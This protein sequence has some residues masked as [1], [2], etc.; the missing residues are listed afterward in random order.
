MS[1]GFKTVNQDALHFITPTIINWVDLF[2]R[3]VYRDIVI[4][5]LRYCQ[6][7]KGLEIF[8]FVV[9]SN[10]L[11][12]LIRSKIGKLSDTIHDFK[13][14]TAKQILQAIENGQESRREWMMNLFEFAAKRHKRNEKY[15]IWTH[16][17]HAEEIYSN[18]FIAQKIKYI[19]ENPVRAGIVEKAEDYLYSSAKALAGLDCLL[20]MSQM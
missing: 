5:S 7:N 14:F 17:N 2:T 12:L 11:H 3:K 6:Q 20:E 10:H 16:E 18:D 1:T 19:H 4:D 9:M 13:S 8:A 15:Q